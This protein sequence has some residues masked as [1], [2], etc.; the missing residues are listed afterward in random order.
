MVKT[1]PQLINKTGLKMRRPR[2]TARIN[3]NRFW[4]SLEESYLAKRTSSKLVI[5]PDLQ[6]TDD[7][8]EQ[9]KLNEE[10]ERKMAAAA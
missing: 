1:N 6:D 9:N 10:L 8:E 7:I 2:L 3:L 4:H 5:L